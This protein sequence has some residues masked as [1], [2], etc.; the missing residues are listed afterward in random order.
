MQYS[1]LTSVGIEI[2]RQFLAHWTRMYTITTVV[3]PVSVTSAVLTSAAPHST[4]EPAA[5]PTALVLGH[6]PCR[7]VAAPGL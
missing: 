6:L 1:G 3:F 2:S 7:Q 5:R 4:S